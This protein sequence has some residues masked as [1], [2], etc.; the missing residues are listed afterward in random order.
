VDQLHLVPYAR[1]RFEKRPPY[2]P[3]L[4]ES[5]QGDRVQLEFVVPL[6]SPFKKEQ[7]YASITTIRVNYALNSFLCIEQYLSQ[8]IAQI[9]Q[10]L[11][12]GSQ[13]AIPNRQRS[14]KTIVTVI[15]ILKILL[16]Y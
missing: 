15:N 1:L 16:I 8:L 11:N 3:V 12:G 5:N 2:Q 10:S 7:K 13:S 14:Q 9:D 6:S 4:L